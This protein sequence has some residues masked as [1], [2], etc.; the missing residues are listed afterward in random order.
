MA[1]RS[2]RQRPAKDEP[3]SLAFASQAV[4]AGNVADATTGA[5][6]TPILMANSYRLPD[7]PS[8]LDWPDSQTLCYTRNSGHD[9]LCPERK[10]AAMEHGEDAAVSSTGAASSRSERGGLFLR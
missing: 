9:Q 2:I 8:L 7:A 1:T 6:R 10:L 3:A 4:H 5:I